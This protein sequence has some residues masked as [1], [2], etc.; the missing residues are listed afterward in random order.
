MC[1][2]SAF[3]GLSFYNTTIIIIGLVFV[4][5]VDERTFKFVCFTAITNLG[6][7]YWRFVIGYTI[8]TDVYTT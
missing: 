5:R 1:I 8:H 7:D 3:S 2:Q 4:K 6:K